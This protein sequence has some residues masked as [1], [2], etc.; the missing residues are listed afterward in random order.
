MVIIGLTGSIGMGK[1]TAAAR[2]RERGIAVFD[3]DAAV[4]ALYDGP[5]AADIEAAFP[6]TVRDGSVDRA[7]LSKALLSAPHRF[8]D[9]EAIVHPRVRENERAFVNAEHARGADYVVLE[10]PL[11]LESKSSH[12]V[13]A[14]VVVSASAEIQRKRVMTRQGMSDAKFDDLLQRQMPDEEKRRRADFIVDT[15][16][17]IEACHSQVDAIISILDSRSGTAFERHWR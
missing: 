9:L 11:L 7:A 16:G 10:I 17:P 2:F 14:I 3:A 4:H 1:S 5:L 15:S 6:G 8:R 13:D 12:L